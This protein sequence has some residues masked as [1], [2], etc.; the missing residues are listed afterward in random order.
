LEVEA[1]SE[2]RLNG[3]CSAGKEEEG[4]SE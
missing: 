1:V 3:Q 2:E 4:Y